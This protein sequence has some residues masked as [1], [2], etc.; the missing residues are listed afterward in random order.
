MGQQTIKEKHRHDRWATV[1]VYNVLV[2]NTQLADAA[3]EREEEEEKEEE[4]EEGTQCAPVP[5]SPH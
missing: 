2:G 5:N 3:P 1:Y 4:E